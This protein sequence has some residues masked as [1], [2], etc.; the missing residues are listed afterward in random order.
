VFVPSLGRRSGCHSSINNIPI[1]GIQGLSATLQSPSSHHS[2][3]SPA[4]TWLQQNPT[5]RAGT[6]QNGEIWQIGGK[7]SRKLQSRRER[8]RE[9]GSQA[10]N[11]TS[12]NWVCSR[13]CRPAGDFWRTAADERAVCERR[14]IPHRPAGQQ[15]YLRLRANRRGKVRCLPER[16]RYASPSDPAQ[17]LARRANCLQQP[18]LKAYFA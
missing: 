15:L 17:P 4:V 10:L 6:S 12:A 16:E 5:G 11:L 13:K 8:R 18:T 3:P 2:G 14:H 9:V 1:S 7:T